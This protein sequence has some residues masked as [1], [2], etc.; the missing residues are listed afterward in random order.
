MLEIDLNQDILKV[1]PKMT[2]DSKKGD[3]GCIGV[4]GGSFEYTGAPFYVAMSALKM[5]ADLAHVFCSKS[6]ALP[7][8]SYSP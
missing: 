3:N 6:A 2:T 4:I 1:F 7:I 8:K 5:G